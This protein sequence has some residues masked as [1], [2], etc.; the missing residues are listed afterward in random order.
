MSSPP[1]QDSAGDLPLGGR[2]LSRVR[3]YGIGKQPLEYPTDLED[4][5]TFEAVLRHAPNARLL[6][7]SAQ[8]FVGGDD[9]ADFLS[10]ITSIIWTNRGR[11]DP[12]RG[13]FT[14]WVYGYMMKAAPNF[15]RRR[16]RL[17]R[18]SDPLDA[19]SLEL[20][21]TASTKGGWEE[22]VRSVE[23]RMLVSRALQADGLSEEQRVVVKLVYM[24]E[25]SLR[26]TA[27]KLETTPGKV[28]YALE[29]ALRTMKS[30][31][32]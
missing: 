22:E 20:E 4:R 8:R 24:E 6:R 21:D 14:T 25:F 1:P 30:E 32:G 23:N 18:V 17:P 26:E 13:K 3:G 27:D 31:V 19:Q 16:A 15:L 2:R 5:Q 12:E 7:A 29:K 28:K 10:E 11:Y 9:C